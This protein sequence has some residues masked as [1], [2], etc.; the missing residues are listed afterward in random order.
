MLPEDWNQKAHQYLTALLNDAE[1]WAVRDARC[2]AI[3]AHE[4]W[5]VEYIQ[6]HG[7]IQKYAS[8][9][10]ES[11]ERIGADVF[12]SNIRKS[13]IGRKLGQMPKGTAEQLMRFPTVYFPNFV[14]I[15][16]IEFLRLLRTAEGTDQIAWHGIARMAAAY[17]S[18]AQNDL[19]RE[20]RRRGSGI[21]PRLANDNIRTL[22][23]NRIYQSEL[24]TGRRSKPILKLT[25]CP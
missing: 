10:V 12:L 16:Q 6:V 23:Q 3:E 8:W 9:Y 4:F 5:T 20:L 18:G 14:P 21:H 22:K 15:L 1:D 13:K 17:I 24:M 7:S 11:E 25:G 19:D 2:V